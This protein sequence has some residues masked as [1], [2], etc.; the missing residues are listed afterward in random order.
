MNCVNLQLF[1]SAA[2]IIAHF[3][4]KPCLQHSSGHKIHV[5]AHLNL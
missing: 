4:L 2:A 5:F 1:I 3:N